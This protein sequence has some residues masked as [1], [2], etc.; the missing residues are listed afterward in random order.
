MTTFNSF[1]WL[2]TKA[3]LTRA[4][5]A[6]GLFLTAI[7]IITGIAWVSG[8]GQDLPADFIFDILTAVGAIG[9]VGGLAMV[10]QLAQDE[11]R[12][13]RRA[14][15]RLIP[16]SPGRLMLAEMLASLVGLAAYALIFGGLIAGLIVASR[17][18]T[19]FTSTVNPASP[20]AFALSVVA[21]AVVVMWLWALV[22][23][24]HFAAVSAATV[25]PH[26]SGGFAQFG[27]GVIVFLVA[28]KLSDLILT[29]F[30]GIF[31][32]GTAAVLNIG[33][34]IR[35]GAGNFTAGAGGNVTVTQL[36]VTSVAYL[37]IF[38]LFTAANLYLLNRW[39]EPK[40]KLA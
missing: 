14:S 29:A 40:Q 34:T 21:T 37:L 10:G 24:I 6:I 2:T 18:T 5:W 27:I 15:V 4:L 36:A 35:R 22:S 23:L 30:D 13:Y 31:H 20:S 12:D 26:A 16:L 25:L 9:I 39:V 33:F 19:S 11:Q 28:G 8:G 38:A 1:F 7:I 3:R 32:V 17:S